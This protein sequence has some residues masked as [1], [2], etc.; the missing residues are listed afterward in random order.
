MYYILLLL[1]TERNHL[2]AVSAKRLALVSGVLG[3]GGVGGGGHVCGCV[4]CVNSDYRRCFYDYN[5]LQTYFGFRDETQ[6]SEGHQ[7][8]NCKFSVH[9]Y[10][11][12]YLQSCKCN[13]C[14]WYIFI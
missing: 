6:D 2:L 10:T 12:V 13:K 7:R 9:T 3:V 8:S 5:L 11:Y 1:S 4:F 14:P